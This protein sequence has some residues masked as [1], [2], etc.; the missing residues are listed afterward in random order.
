MHCQFV[1]KVK[2]KKLSY[3]HGCREI[4]AHSWFAILIPIY[5]AIIHVAIIHV[6]L[7]TSESSIG[8]AH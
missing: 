3:K 1:V 8:K 2:E 6:N 5:S 4:M 7:M